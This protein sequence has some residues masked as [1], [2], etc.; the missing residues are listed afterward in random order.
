MN[1]L[2]AVV[3]GATGLTGNLILEEL[4][5]DDTF[6]AVRILVRNPVKISHPKLQQ[7][8]VDF[9]DIDDYTQK[10]GEGDVI[11]CC[12]GT[13]K[14]KVKGDKAAYTK[15][16]FDI[17]VNTARIGVSKGFKQFQIVSAVGAN[18]NS[19]NFYLQ[20][21]GKTEN[22]L[23][24]FHYRGIGIFQPSILN[25]NRKEK[26][27]GE[28]IIQTIMDL[29]SMFLLGPLEKY[30]AIG[31]NNVAKAMVNES[32]HQNTGVHYYRYAEIMDLA[33]E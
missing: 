7:E 23:K 31:A 21:K 6:K 33:R 20:L 30:R 14:K 8:I 10:F 12:I 9:N 19:S 18:E 13:T 16:D 24:Q 29:I 11:F 1:E 3:I 32:K 4:L 27:M 28:Q 25:G 15:I 5:K 2:K 17:P 26:R 22:A